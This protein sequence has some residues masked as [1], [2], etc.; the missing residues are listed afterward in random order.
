MS[1]ALDLTAGDGMAAF[2]YDTV[3]ANLGTLQTRCWPADRL[4]KLVDAHAEEKSFKQ[5]VRAIGD[6]ASRNA[7]ISQAHRIGLPLRDGAEM[8]RPRTVKPPR[9]AKA[10]APP[11]PP[12]P[13]PA[14]IRHS[15]TADVVAALALPGLAPVLISALAPSQC[16]WPVGDPKAADF[17]F[18]GRLKP[19][20]GPYCTAH[21]RAAINTDETARA[22]RG[23]VDRLARVTGPIRQQGARA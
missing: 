8:N 5:I 14:S 9:A 16:K 7:C 13:S 10:K 17:A 12:K 15:R 22:F 23:G 6:G 11:R 3:R 2:D 18:C 1:G 20:A 19:L 4:L 21:H